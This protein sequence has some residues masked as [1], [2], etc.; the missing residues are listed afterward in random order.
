MNGASL[1]FWWCNGGHYLD[2]R[3]LACPWSGKRIN[4][5]LHDRVKRLS[6]RSPKHSYQELH[7][8]G[9][10]ER[11]L[12]QLLLVNQEHTNAIA[13]PCGD[14]VSRALADLV[15][16]RNRVILELFPQGI[17]RSILDN[18]APE[19]EY[20]YARLS[21]PNE[22]WILV[23]DCALQRRAATVRDDPAAERTFV[24]R[25]LGASWADIQSCV[26]HARDPERLNLFTLKRWLVWRDAPP[27]GFG[28]ELYEIGRQREL[29][30][31][32][33]YPLI[34]SGHLVFPIA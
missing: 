9:M 14:P 1:I 34:P 12:L 15:A 3:Q 21:G 11:D 18:P 32:R 4:L 7:A 5:I 27:L 31:T 24:E 17:L 26:I 8:V 33:H 22:E 19:S 30:R 10:S 28:E 13:L 29:F 2:A 25:A 23:D 20:W 16:E 6:T